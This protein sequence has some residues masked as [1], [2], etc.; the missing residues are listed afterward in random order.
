MNL[1]K[2]IFKN[3]SE[4][5]MAKGCAYS[6]CS[7]LDDEKRASI[8]LLLLELAQSNDNVNDFENNIIHAVL[9]FLGIVSD[10]DINTK[11]QLE[12]KR[13]TDQM[14]IKEAMQNLKSIEI[15]QKR[16][17]LLWMCA[18][19]NVDEPHTRS[20]TLLAD[21]AITMGVD[22]DR[23]AM[24]EKPTILNMTKSFKY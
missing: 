18:M 19:V 24:E 17:V 16:D 9:N 20:F 13:I 23:F 7:A 6:F 1:L 14:Q 4:I 8:V 21:T 15:E 10:V 3:R 11:G 2:K 12:L 22:I 5:G